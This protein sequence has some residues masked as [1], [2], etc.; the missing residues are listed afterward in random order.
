M[1]YN[2][3]FSPMKIGTMEVKNRIVM[4]AAELGVGQIDG[5]VNER[6]ARYYEERAKGGVGLI[7]TGCCR[8]DDINPAS[9]AQIG[10]THDYHIEPMRQ[11]VERIH[12]HGAKLCVQLH[13]AGRQGY[14]S[15][16]NSFPLVIPMT[17]AIP[18]SENLLWKAAPGLLKLEEKGICFTVQAPSKGEISKHAGTRLHA[19]SRREVR[20]CIRLFVEAA[21]RC[22]KAGVDAVELHGGHGYLIQQF[23]SPHTNH[24]TDEYGGSLENRFRF[25]AE[26]ITGIKSAC[27]EDYPVILRLTVDEMYDR[28]GR[29]GVG[30]G[31][32]EGVEFARRAEALGVDAI[33]VTSATYD[34]YSYWLET[35]SFVPGWRAYLAKAVKDA[36]SI[37][38]I[39][40]NYIR[41]PEQA[42]RQLENGTQDFI[43]SARNFIC[44]S[45]W[46]NK[47]RDGREDEIRR[48]IGCVNC[49]RS[50]VTEGVT[51]GKPG[52]CAL[53]VAMGREAEFAALPR[54][55]EGRC[56]VVVGAGPA[57]LTAAELLARRG[58]EVTVFEK[59]EKPGGQVITAAACNLKDKLYWCIEDL[60]TAL[61]KLGVEVRLGTAPTA[62]E[63]AAMKPDFVIVATGGTP[64]RPGSIPGIGRDNVHL[65]PEIL[66]REKRIENSRVVV[67]G[68]GITGLETAEMLG[69]CNNRVTVI[70]MADAIAPGAWYQLVDDELERIRP[71]TVFKT[72]SKLLE[73]NDAG[74]VIE[75]V[76]TGARETVP[77]DAVVLSMGVRPANSLVAELEK[78]N[79]PAY[80]VGDAVKSGT[81]AGACHIACDTVM[82]IK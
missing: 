11:M 28:I 69:E 63:L 24:R 65:A 8:I 30:Y 19:M 60:M 31:L 5:R 10:M 22:K 12:R 18:A 4:T 33:N 57:G 81:I 25:L 47:V 36:V 82:N 20:R 80:P 66:L 34:A 23:L 79:I 2:V 64:V 75:N 70:E 49:M 40:A 61:E 1:A 45:E 9:F 16:N 15:C 76:A 27:G 52:K 6:T 72:S 13:H 35:T 73:I 74:A 51:I 3:M 42:E 77:A 67:V 26:L 38:V 59:G 39:A 50:L 53:N 32:D 43:G 37:P 55:G 58:F 17:R 14:G 62:R 56:A 54:D 21:E 68:S 78:L 48:C 71:D 7:I 41:S 44:D 46:A 29:P